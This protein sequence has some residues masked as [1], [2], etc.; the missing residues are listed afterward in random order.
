MLDLRP[1]WR[2]RY[3]SQG[4]AWDAAI[5]AGIDAS[6]LEFNLSLTPTERL[7]QHEQLMRTFEQF[8]GAALPEQR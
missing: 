6:Q 8:H 5:E 3:R 1:V 7:E 2:A 4:P